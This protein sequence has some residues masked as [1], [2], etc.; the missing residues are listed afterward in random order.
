MVKVVLGSSRKNKI[1]VNKK[2]IIHFFGFLCSVKGR[3]VTRKTKRLPSHY[4]PIPTTKQVKQLLNV[5]ETSYLC[6][7]K[8]ISM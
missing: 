4:P 1:F 7:L 5:L 8:A 6:K 2:N 3:K